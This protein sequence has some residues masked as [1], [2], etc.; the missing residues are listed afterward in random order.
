MKRIILLAAVI[1]LAIGAA[2]GLT[3]FADFQKQQ[4]TSLTYDETTEYSSDSMEISFNY[5]DTFY[6]EALNV[7][8]KCADSSAKLYYTTNGDTPTESS[9]LFKD[10]ISI[11]S[12]STVSATTIKVIAV[13]GDKKSDVVTKTYITGKNVFE[14][15]DENTLVFVLSS[16]SYNLYDYYYGVLVEG[17]LRDEYLNSDEYNGGELDYTAPANWYIRG[18]ESERDM[19]VEVYNNEG[20]QLISQ[21]AGGRVVGGASRANTQ[22]SW[23]LIARTSYDPENGKFKYPFFYDEETEFGDFITRYDRITLRDNANDREFASIRDEVS[24]R[25]AD[26]AGFPDTQAV[27]PAAVFLNSEYY[28]FAWLHEAYG[29][30]YLATNYGGNRDNFYIIGNKESE[31][32]IDEDSDTV[33][34]KKA[35]EDWNY[36]LQLAYGEQDVDTYKIG[37]D[38]KTNEDAVFGYLTDDRVFEEFCSLVDIDNFMLYYAMQIYIDN[39]DWPGNNYKAW[40]YY[41]SEGEAVTNEFLDGKWRFLWFDVEFA[42]GL[43]GN[44][45]K[46]KTLTNV[47][48]GNHMQ[49]ASRLLK[50][51]LERE[52]MREKF[53]NTMCDVMYGAFSTENALT[54]IEE[55]IEECD[56]ECMYALKNGYTSSWAN[57]W[58]FAD[59]R[60]QIRDFAERRPRIMTRNLCSEF[61]LEE[62]MYTVTLNNPTGAKS[63]LNSQVIEE[64]G[65]KSASYFTVYSVPL[66]FETYDGYEFDH[67]EVNGAAY[68]EEMLT[69]DCSMADESGNVN[70]KLYLNKT[71]TLSGLVISEVYTSGE[72]DWIELYNG[73]D[74]TVSTKGYYLSDDFDILDRFDIPATSIAPKST[75]TIALKNNKENS[76]LMK[77]AANFNLKVGETVYL[78]DS[79]GNVHSKCG[80]VEM[81]ENKSASL[82]IDGKYH[83][84][85]ITE[86]YHE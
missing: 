63:K 43:Y 81:D 58:T 71:E 1:L 2:I 78:S 80:I 8:I 55:C 68:S 51:L 14:R 35:V 12:R 72:G 44:G 53:T 24:Q 85:D 18:R 19:Y 29:E 16:D 25:L 9:K 7:E 33:E 48:T 40:R 45:Y 22:K 49:G 76:A 56:K 69:V 46:D 36:I 11:P 79:E 27:R 38:G 84:G 77:I 86:G 37:E 6:K 57:E 15:F 5:K 50:A 3:C 70:V 17:Y 74:E 66:S 39:K 21:A 13:D 41:P 23:R 52:D 62:E 59:S 34:E 83:I 61:G 30:D 47:L 42:W 67:W 32:E 82:G 26:M 60:Q 73:Y 10:K 54:V 4:P 75:L 20:K 65:T 28:G 64:S 31:M